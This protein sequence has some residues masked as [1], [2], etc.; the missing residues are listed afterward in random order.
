M[1]DERTRIAQKVTWIGF[2]VNL[3]LTA[4]K[5]F[6]GIF[7]K[8]TAMIADGVHSLSDFITDVIVIV[9]IG[10]SGKEHDQDHR[11]GHGKYETFATLLISLALIIVGF[12]IFWSGLS[13]VIETIQGKT[14]LQPTYLALAAAVLSIIVKEG[15]FWYTKK[16]GKKIN[17]QAVIANAWHH[18]SDA[19]SSI[20]TTLGISGAIFLSDS[21]RILD[22]IAGIIV[23]F[24]IVKVAI[25][26]GLPSV[27]ELLERSLPDQTENKIAEII[28]SNPEIRAFHNL[29]TR[30]IGSIYAIDVHIKLDPEISFVRSHDIATETEIK[31]REQFGQNTITSIHTEPLK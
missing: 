30:K 6:A 25:E 27:H 24:F 16:A 28:L 2:F 29:K 22:P 7:G 11:Y 23:S 3:I 10:V 4:I 9:F 8:S 19:F 17:N 31:L 14:I 18:R 13:K 20:G 21:W 15:L 5:L 1:K 26:L 12:G